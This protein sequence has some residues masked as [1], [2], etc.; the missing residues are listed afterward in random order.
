[1]QTH[2]NGPTDKVKLETRETTMKGT[3]STVATMW[4]E[5]HLL[6]GGT[7]TFVVEGVEIVLTKRDLLGPDTENE[8]D[9]KTS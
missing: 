9:K 2:E 5:K 8:V 4:L 3:G 7:T 1:M 6:E